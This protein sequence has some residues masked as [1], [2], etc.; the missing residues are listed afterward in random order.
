MSGKAKQLFGLRMTGRG[1][2]EIIETDW[3]ALDT[4]AEEEGFVPDA[5]F[6]G[7]WGGL[8]LRVY[9]FPSIIFFFFFF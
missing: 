2:Q 5:G 9:L 1:I 3:K 7:L 4:D 8:D 6:G